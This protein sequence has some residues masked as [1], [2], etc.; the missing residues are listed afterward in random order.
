MFFIHIVVY[1]NDIP[2]CTGLDTREKSMV[3]VRGISDA[4]HHL[5]VGPVLVHHRLLTK[6]LWPKRT[7]RIFADMWIGVTIINQNIKFLII[8]I[9]QIILLNYQINKYVSPPKISLLTPG[10]QNI[11]HPW[12]A[13]YLHALYNSYF[14]ACQVV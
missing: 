6:Y 14:I 10:R 11:T 13:L 8:E 7:V 4:S 3:E 9:S 12:P 2:S 1:S 5:A